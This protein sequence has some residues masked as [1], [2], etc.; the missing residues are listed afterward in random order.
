MRAAIGVRHRSTEDDEG[1]PRSPVNATPTTAQVLFVDSTVRQV[2]ISVDRWL[3]LFGFPYLNNKTKVARDP[4][5]A[6]NR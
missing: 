6:I 3:W 4:N 5:G 2:L 1:L